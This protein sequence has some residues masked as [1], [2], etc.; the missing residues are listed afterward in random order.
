MKRCLIL[1]L[2]SFQGL[3]AQVQF[4]TKVSK[5]PPFGR[6]K[7]CELILLWFIDEQF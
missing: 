5:T 6:M 3:L 2:L 7:G 4:E 1:I